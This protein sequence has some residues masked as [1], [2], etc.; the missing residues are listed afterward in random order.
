MS[1]DGTTATHYARG[2]AAERAGDP[3]TAEE[4]Y[5]VAAENCH[6]MSIK[7]LEGLAKNAGMRNEAEHWRRQLENCEEAAQKKEEAAQKGLDTSF[8]ELRGR[9]DEQLQENFLGAAE[10]L[11]SQPEAHRLPEGWAKERTVEW[12]QDWASRTLDQKLDAEQA[13]AVASQGNI[14]V[15]ARA[16][17][18][19]TRTLVARAAFLVLHCGVPAHQILLLA[20]NKA[21][22]G[23]MDRRLKEHFPEG[24]ERPFAMTFHALAWATVHPDGTI[25]GDSETNP[26]LSQFVQSII[27][28]L[29]NSPEGV[30]RL[31]RAMLAKYESSW[32]SIE[33]L[34]LGGGKEGYFRNL[35]ERSHQTYKG[36]LVDSPA[37]QV[38][39]NTL[40]ANGVKYHYGRDYHWN[41]GIFRAGFE[42]ISQG[43][44]T[45]VIDHFETSRS[46]RS[47]AAMSEFFSRKE[48]P[49]FVVPDEVVSKGSSDCADWVVQRLDD[50]GVD[51]R[52]RTEDEIW[53]EIKNRDV[54]E[55][56][57][58]VTNFFTRARQM[59]M[60]PADLGA[61]VSNHTAVS[62]AEEY[63]L[64]LVTPM[65]RDYVQ[66]L[67]TQDR[68]DFAGL[69]WQAVARIQRGSTEF[70]RST[71]HQYGN[72]SDI[73]Y[74]L[75]DEYQDF[76]E[77]F[78]QLVDEIVGVSKSEVFAVG[79]DWQ[80]ING[81]AGSHPSYF[82]GYGQKFPGAKLLT[83]RTNYRSPD[84]IVDVGNKIMQD[85]GDPAISGLK[86]SGSVFLA[87]A[88]TDNATADQSMRFHGDTQTP[89]LLRILRREV[90]RG[91]K[92]IAVLV[93]RK[94]PWTVRD[95]D[96]EGK[97]ETLAGLEGYL[98]EQLPK[99]T[100]VN[101]RVGTAHSF[102][103]GEAETVVVA[104]ADYSYP[105]IHPGWELTRVLGDSHE[106]SLAE[107]R[108]L[109]YVASTRAQQTHIYLAKGEPE[110]FLDELVAGRLLKSLNLDSC[111]RI[112][113]SDTE[114]C[115]LR[116][117]N[118][119]DVKTWLKSKDFKWDPKRSMWRRSI[120]CQAAA[121]LLEEVAEILPEWASVTLVN[122]SKDRD[123]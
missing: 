53:G 87:R 16:G 93:R 71:P 61:R 96:W 49:L 91:V 9:F 74:I 54:E 5:R 116:V 11:E 34:G 40:Y 31:R 68:D 100:A 33:K 51:R 50:L 67:A 121:T 59:G 101:L 7:R 47:K 104:D 58:A 120:E 122:P 88:S 28:E 77:M 114:Y 35:S 90:S 15:T 92:D 55:F 81:F 62:E 115:E 46:S 29:L 39:A 89:A 12:V 48:V 83:I 45:A 118:G 63:F 110:G 19:K 38:I 102:K 60:S 1:N 20:F 70:S 94:K 80:A 10:W 108:R 76:S 32:A 4:N 75:I 44:P 2:R 109:F 123:R 21:A 43:K 78:S 14:R 25:M 119:Y 69:M 86:A 18:G 17:S 23:E 85:Q 105:L 111:P 82:H 73:R 6:R 8:D 112:P 24:V 64:Q 117:T 66:E 65:Y 95:S 106:K 84:V 79:D 22:A 99:E 56:S 97:I 37:H 30:K 36:D 57:K 42:I 26:V 98:L 72:L 41:G 52:E 3:L 107:E 13:L 103:G 113:I 27:Y